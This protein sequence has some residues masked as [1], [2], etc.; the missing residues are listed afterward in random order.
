MK[1]YLI[2]LIVSFST[3]LVVAGISLIN[4]EG[5][6]IPFTQTFQEWQVTSQTGDEI[7]FDITFENSKDKKTIITAELKP[8]SNY[9]PS[10]TISLYDKNNNPILDDKDK[11]LTIKWEKKCG[12]EMCYYLSLTNVQSVNINNYIKLGQNSIEMEYIGTNSL[13]Y[14]Y[15]WGNTTFT[16]YQDEET[17]SNLSVYWNESRWKMSAIN[18]DKINRLRNYVYEINSTNELIVLEKIREGY[19][20]PIFYSYRRTEDFWNEER[21]WY[22][23]EDVCRESYSDCS[24]DD[25]SIS[26]RS[27]NFIDPAI[28]NVTGCATLSIANQLYQQN[29]SIILNRF[30]NDCIIITASNVTFDG[31]GFFITNNR[32]MSVVFSNQ[33]NSTIINT[34]FTNTGINAWVVQSNN[35][36]LVNSQ[37]STI[38]NNIFHR[39]S[40]GIQLVNSNNTLTESNLIN[41]SFIGIYNLQSSNNI[42]QNE[43]II[44]IKNSSL[45][46][47]RVG[48]MVIELSNNISFEN[49]LINNTTGNLVKF[50]GSS[51]NLF[52]NSIL[53]NSS[54]Q[55]VVSTF[56][57]E[58]EGSCS[59][60]GLSECFQI[61]GEG[62]CN[63]QAN[64][65]ICFWDD[66]PGECIDADGGPLC[67]IM[68]TE[69]HCV[70]D[71]N[72]LCDWTLG[73]PTVNSIN[74]IFLNTTYDS[75]KELIQVDGGCVGGQYG[76]EFECEFIWIQSACEDQNP[77]CVWGGS[78][79]SEGTSI[80]GFC[81][82]MTTEENC[83]YTD[84]QC[85]WNY[86]KINLLRKWWYVANV[87]DTG[88]NQVEDVNITAFNST[89]GFVF[90]TTTD[91]NGLTPL[92][93]LLEYVNSG[94]VQIFQ[95]LYTIWANEDCHPRFRN[96]T[97]NVTIEETNINH[98]IIIGDVQFENFEPICSSNCNWNFP[99][100]VPSPFNITIQSAIGIFNLNRKIDFL[101]TNQYFNMI[102]GASC[103][104][105]ISSSGSIE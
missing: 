83:G 46:A 23:F 15:G 17:L 103:E 12:E 25:N 4:Q 64:D 92:Q 55:D 74:N 80:T 86:T 7:N 36:E 58:G 35:V 95:G 101:G 38:R 37:N 2:I 68:E 51:N 26:F 105:N 20:F 79:C 47:D 40:T 18:N 11:P 5:E 70:T 57:P 94:G 29:V 100:D 21:Q 75:S 44:S 91:S 13:I 27:Y 97:Y 9:I 34:N 59:D 33:F 31:N 32:A 10:S 19:K 63:D 43:T 39:S 99:I 61:I 71:T 8:S 72:S 87:S 28:E 96:E 78:S 66:G 76:D 62:G 102:G 88:N 81:E 30:R 67:I 73:D 50:I 84:D 16:I 77:L 49:T 90:N 54:G 24:W 42:H 69:D 14:H 104:L 52:N 1:L 93:K 60:A 41:G 56:K 98:N 22:D 53:I 6:I 89:G 65:A 85:V 48:S 45:N 3:G 82:F